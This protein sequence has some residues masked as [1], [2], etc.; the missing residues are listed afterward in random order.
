MNNKL[1]LRTPSEVLPTC[2]TH[3]TMVISDPAS[4]VVEHTVF[5]HVVLLYVRVGVRYVASSLSSGRAIVT[6]AVQHCT[7]AHCCLRM[8]KTFVLPSRQRLCGYTL[9]T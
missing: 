2:S 7:C 3:E 5:V 8:F 1:N 9:E 6:G 4:L